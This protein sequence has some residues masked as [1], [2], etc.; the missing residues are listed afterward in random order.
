MGPADLPPHSVPPREL[1]P[2]P[3]RA[4][5]GRD[6]LIE[7]VIDRAET[8]T[9]IA[10]IGAWGTGKTPI[11]LAVLH[12]HRTKE[13]SGDNRRSIRCDQFPTSR[14]HFLSRLSKVIGARAENPESLTPLQPFLSSGEM[15]IVLDNAESILDPQGTNAQ[16]I[17]WVVQWNCRLSFGVKN[18]SSERQNLKLCAPSTFTRRLAPR[19]TYS[20]AELSSGVSKREQK[21]WPS[22]VDRTSTVSPGNNA[23]SYTY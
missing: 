3:L 21:G 14:T 13:R 12:H 22:P 16:E 18:E 4:C 5:F 9:P 7:K 2:P 11:A 17:C 10:L 6:E 1:P 19:R 8:L 15:I 23:S 20:N